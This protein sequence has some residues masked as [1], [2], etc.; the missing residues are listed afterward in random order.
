MESINECVICYE[1]ITNSVKLECNHVFCLKCIFLSSKNNNDIVKCSLCRKVIDFKS[2]TNKKDQQIIESQNIVNN[3]ER[4]PNIQ[5]RRERADRADHYF[6]CNCI[7]CE[8]RSVN[9]RSLD[10]IKN[11]K[12]KLREL[13]EY[14]NFKR[15]EEKYYWEYMGNINNLNGAGKTRDRKLRSYDRSEQAKKYYEGLIHRLEEYINNVPIIKQTRKEK[16]EQ[17]KTIFLSTYNPQKQQQQKLICFGNYI[18][19]QP[20]RNIFNDD[21]Y[22]NNIINC[23]AQMDDRERRDKLI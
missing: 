13:G 1:K 12:Q 21:G 5:E 23:N 3:N 11:R 19:Q 18:V 16:R 8:N 6:F 14:R 22:Y 4:L 7:I 10:I 2:N 9:R 20:K 17:W 15:L